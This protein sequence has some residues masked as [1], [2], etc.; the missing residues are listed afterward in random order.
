[1]ELNIKELE[2][3]VVLTEPSSYNAGDLEQICLYDK[4]VQ[5][6]NKLKE[7]E[8]E[9]KIVAVLIQFL[10]D[11]DKD[12]KIKLLINEGVIS[13]EIFSSVRQKLRILQEEYGIQT[14]SDQP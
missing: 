2:I 4:L 14:M 10:L 12:E 1:M 7:Q 13:K 3:L 6:L 8:L 5:A 9:E 11:V